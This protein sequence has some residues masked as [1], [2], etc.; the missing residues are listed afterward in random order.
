MN[1]KKKRGLLLIIPC[2]LMVILM[3]VLF[4]QFKQ[5]YQKSIDA[6]EFRYHV[7]CEQ[8]EL[9]MTQEDVESILLQYG[10]YGKSTGNPREIGVNFIDP[11]VYRQ[12]GGTY[13]ALFYDN[14]KYI[15][16]YIPSSS[17][18]GYIPICQNP[19]PKPSPFKV[20]VLWIFQ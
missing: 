1:I 2:L 19:T 18:D 8:I 11:D 13:L 10:D 9:G 5:F 7:F 14:E 6:T 17:L 12:F 4:G 3:S 16:A 15:G 20:F